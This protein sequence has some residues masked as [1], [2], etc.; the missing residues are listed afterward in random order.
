MNEEIKTEQATEDHGDGDKQG[1]IDAVAEADKVAERLEAANAKKEELL[2][3][4]ERIA[5]QS[6]S[7]IA[8]SAPKKKEEPLHKTDPLQYSKDVFAGKENPMR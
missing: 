8:G 3:R 5:A 1:A 7:M 4:E 6:G 2:A